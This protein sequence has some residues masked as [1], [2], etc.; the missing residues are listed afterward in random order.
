M[1]K[2]ESDLTDSLRNGNIEILPDGEYDKTKHVS[3]L[4]N[5]SKKFDAAGVNLVFTD[6]PNKSDLKNASLL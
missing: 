4:Q 1:Q 2:A 6:D 5:I 3:E